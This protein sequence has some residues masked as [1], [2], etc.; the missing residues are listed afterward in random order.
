M[1]SKSAAFPEK[2]CG[3]TPPTWARPFLLLAAVCLPVTAL[4]MAPTVTYGAPS[5]PV[6]EIPP[7]YERQQVEQGR[8]FVKAFQLTGVTAGASEDASVLSVEPQTLSQLQ[9]LVESR[10]VEGQGASELGEYGFTPAEIERILAQVAEDVRRGG[11][12]E[13]YAGL[14]RELRQSPARGS[15]GLTVGQING[16]AEAVT[17]HIRSD[18]YFLA[19]A[20]VPAQ[21]VSDGIVEIRVL[22]GTFGE[23][24]VEGNERYSE[25]QIEG[26]FEE[27][28]G[29]PVTPE[30]VREP[31]LRV[32]DY[33]GVTVESSWQPGAEVG[34]ADL[35]V[36]VTEKR[37]DLFLRADNHLTETTGSWRTMGSWSVNNLTGKWGDRLTFSGVQ[38]WAPS[39]DHFGGINWAIPL[40][41]PE[42]V[43]DVGWATDYFE[44]QEFA[45]LGVAGRSRVGH[46]G[47]TRRFIR[48]RDYNLNARVDFAAKRGEVLID[49]TL[50]VNEDKLS[51][52]G[53]EVVSES[54]DRESLSHTSARVR[55][56]LGIDNFWNS[57][58][59]ADAI[60]ADARGVPTTR[61]GGASGEFADSSFAKLSLDLQRMQRFSREGGLEFRG[62]LFGQASDDVLSNLETFSVGGPYSN[63]GLP[64]GSFQVDTALS[65]SLEFAYRMQSLNG[66]P[67]L[68]VFYDGTLGIVTDPLD[69]LDKKRYF[70]SYGIGFEMLGFANTSFRLQAGRLATGDKAVLRRNPL[71]D[72]EDTQFWI[73]VS[74]RF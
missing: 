39:D 31:L 67:G 1:E 37:H 49:D 6:D 10:R 30:S 66:Q 46:V 14:V 33:P 8:V 65:T 20:V 18:G 2:A 36:K 13:D 44:L 7:R 68:F 70:G 64:V 47:W 42:S 28:A 26:P 21:D 34:S 12:A 56:D 3:T 58:S 9:S 55:V 41:G 40:G 29:Q 11:S 62:K 71:A 60:A 22:K 72:P 73:D 50:P 48:S 35:K 61:Q 54:T 51:V 19:Q 4:M 24:L 45:A 17:Q 43:L 69:P 23:V 5:G 52:L 38:T 16:I 27:L 63:R 25:H 15:V 74:R 32:Q 59:Q 53:A 57:Y